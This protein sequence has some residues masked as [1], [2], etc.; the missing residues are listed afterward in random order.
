MTRPLLYLTTIALLTALAFWAY[1]ENYA[2]QTALRRMAALDAEIRNLQQALSV[3][4]AEWAYLNRPDRLRD[5]VGLNFERVPLLPLEP[6]QFAETRDVAMP[7]ADILPLDIIPVEVQGE[8]TE[9]D[10]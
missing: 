1:R 10:L 3:Q 4:R 8:L 2:T 9:A 5:L 7:P 6:G